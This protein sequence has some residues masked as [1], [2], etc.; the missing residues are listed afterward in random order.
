[1]TNNLQPYEIL[2]F[3]ITFA[4]ML[5]GLLIVMIC[6]LYY[7]TIGS[8]I[9]FYMISFGGIVMIVMMLVWGCTCD[10]KKNEEGKKD[11]PSK[12]KIEIQTVE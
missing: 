4:I 11:E 6:Q 9:G 3:G 5:L 12:E 7:N 1:M 2:G 10:C 8:N